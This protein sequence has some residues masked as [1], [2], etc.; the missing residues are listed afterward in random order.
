MKKVLLSL[1]TIALAMSAN[2]Q[3]FI[4]GFAGANTTATKTVT[5]LDTTKPVKNSFH[6]APIVGFELSE[7]LEAGVMLELSTSKSVYDKIDD[8]DAW[9]KNNEWEI[10]PFIR[11]ELI[12]FGNFAVKAQAVASFGQSTP[13]T[14]AGSTKTKGWKTNVLALNVTPIISYELNEHFELESSLNFF[15][16]GAY[17]SSTKDPDDKNIKTVKNSIGLNANAEQISTLGGISIGF[18]YKL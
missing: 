18:V 1:A 4:G 12:S 17:T 15:S 7:K 8:K 10:A 16:L 13:V 5:S 14:N 9:N 11:Y 3:I 2:A 6:L